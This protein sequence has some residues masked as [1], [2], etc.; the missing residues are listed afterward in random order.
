[1]IIAQRKDPNL[2]NIYYNTAFINYLAQLD[3]IALNHINIVISEKPTFYRSYFIKGL[4][5][6]KRKDYIRVC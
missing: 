4:I 3:D 1:M 5:L 6:Q 2:W